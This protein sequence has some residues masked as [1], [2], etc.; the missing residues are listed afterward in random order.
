MMAIESSLIPLPSE[1]VI[2]PAAYLGWTRGFDFLGVHLMGWPALIG[3][4]VAGMV[5]SW[6]GA[7]AMYWASRIAGRPSSRTPVLS[8]FACDV[9]EPSFPFESTV[10]G[11]A[12]IG[13]VFKLR[14]SESFAVAL[15]IPQI[16]GEGDEMFF[17]HGDSPGV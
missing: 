5:G 1:L 12:E 7:T 3:L 11:M 4:V 13:E 9:V 10:L 14:G 6:V 15:A 16:L 2:P 17:A 8:A